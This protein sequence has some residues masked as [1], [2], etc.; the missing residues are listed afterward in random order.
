MKRPVL[1]MKR[2]VRRAVV[3]AIDPGTSFGWAVWSVGDE[4]LG[5]RLRPAPAGSVWPDE[6]WPLVLVAAGAADLTPPPNEPGYRWARA[7]DVLDTLSERYRP[8]VYALEDV[9]RHAGTHA[10]HVYGGLRAS[11][12]LAA[13]ERSCRVIGVPVQ[14]GKLVLAGRGDASKADVARAARELSGVDVGSDTADAIA[15]GRAAVGYLV[16]GP[17]PAAVHRR[18]GSAP[19]R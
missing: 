17:P 2:Q 7:R 12:E 9:R 1:P 4:L 15:I 3:L 11:I 10:A 5:V 6:P 16:S 18:G 13:W 19:G 14:H 8:T